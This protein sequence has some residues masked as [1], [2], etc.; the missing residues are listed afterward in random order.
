MGFLKLSRIPSSDASFIRYEEDQEIQQQ[1]RIVVNMNEISCCL[2]CRRFAAQTAN[3][4]IINFGKQQ[5]NKKDRRQF[6]KASHIWKSIVFNPL[7][8][9]VNFTS[10]VLDKLIRNKKPLSINILFHSHVS[11]TTAFVA[12]K[13]NSR[14]SRAIVE[15]IIFVRLGQKRR[16][17][18]TCT[19]T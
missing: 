4:Q 16:L 9:S 14:Q 8:M 10:F 18:A 11:T 19:D 7:S 6:A 12:F 17:R 13:S 1:Q 3:M 5:T 15:Y 2:Q